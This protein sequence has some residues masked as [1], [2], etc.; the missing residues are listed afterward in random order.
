MPFDMFQTLTAKLRTLLTSTDP[1]RPSPEQWQSRSLE[2]RDHQFMV[3]AIKFYLF[4][5][6]MNR[7]QYHD[8]LRDRMIHDGN[9]AF[10]LLTTYVD[11]GRFALEYMEFINDEIKTLRTLPESILN[12]LTIP[13]RHID[14]IELQEQVKLSFTD[15]DAGTKYW[16]IYIPEQQQLYYQKTALSSD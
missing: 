6:Q 7:D 4:S 13:P 16:L 1:E 5:R 11:E 8:E 3:K 14:D 9:V 15:S 10:S 2:E 12:S